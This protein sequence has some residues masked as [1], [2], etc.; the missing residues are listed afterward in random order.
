MSLDKRIQSLWPRLQ[1]KKPHMPNF[2]SEIRLDGIRGIEG[3]KINFDYPVSVIAGANASGKST[4]LFAAACAYDVPGAKAKDYVPS[5]LFPD[6]RPK[7]GGVRKDGHPNISLEYE[8]ETSGGHL[9]MRWSRGKSWNRSYF[10]RK[11]AKQ[12]QRDLYLRTLSNLSNPS[13]VRNVLQMSRLPKAPKEHLLSAVQIDFAQQ[14]FPFDYSEVVHLSSGNKNLLFATQRGGAAYSEFHMA[15]GERSI[16]RLSREI[17]QLKDALILIDEVEAGLH[18]R[19]QQL[20]MLQLQQLALRNDLQ[21]IV[22]SHSPVILDS[23]PFNA[24]IFLDRDDQGKVVVCPPY[25][26]VIQDALYGRLDSVLKLLCEDEIAESV[27]H[28]VI[29]YLALHEGVRREQITIGRDTGAEEFPAHAAAFKR[30]GLLD[31]F[32]FVLDGDRNEKAVEEKIRQ[33]AAGWQGPILFLPGNCAPEVWVWECLSRQRQQW[34]KSL[35]MDSST[36]RKHMEGLNA[37]YHAAADSPAVVAKHK[38]QNLADRLNK[39]V[40]DICRFVAQQEIERDDSE[41]RPLANR[42]KDTVT[43]WRLESK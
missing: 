11:K 4:V 34:A 42:L 5:T 37:D 40:P 36:L 35:H 30:F 22:T 6:Y 27:L 2:L 12:P 7:T 38:L 39:T 13:E 21:I 1:G 28:G 29:D 20:L 3:V 41:I 10:G 19:I 32:V 18:P 26:D 16:L 33:R 24:R 8:Y 17:A 31:N 25:R 15:A 23:V 9:S 14:M 43:Q